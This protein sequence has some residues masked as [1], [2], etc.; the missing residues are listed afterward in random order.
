MLMEYSNLFISHDLPCSNLFISLFHFDTKLI[1]RCGIIDILVEMD[2][3]LRPGGAVI[4]RD[5][6]DLVL[7]VKKDADR[8]GWRSRTV[9]TENWALDPVKLLIVDKSFPIP[10]SS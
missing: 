3:I 10:G 8:L 6:A 4:V 9:D 7:K 1:L 5:R 2:R